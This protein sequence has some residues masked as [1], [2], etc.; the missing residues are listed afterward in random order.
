M[1]GFRV[2]WT[3]IKSHLGSSNNELGS[4]SLRPYASWM[5]KDRP[6]ILQCGE[7]GLRPIFSSILVTFT[8][9]RAPLCL[10]LGGYSE[11]MYRVTRASVDFTQRSPYSHPVIFNHAIHDNAISLAVTRPYIN[12]AGEVDDGWYQI[13]TRSTIFSRGSDE[14]K[15]LTAASLQTYSTESLQVSR[16]VRRVPTR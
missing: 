14:H 4:S 5:S 10:T 15:W 6:A 1:T 16:Q 12:T 7:Y 8:L 13:S 9:S 11:Y 3:A 2:I